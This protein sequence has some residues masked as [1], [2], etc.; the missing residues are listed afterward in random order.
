MNSSITPG[1]GRV[2]A[3]PNPDILKT[4]GQWNLGLTI[5][6]YVRI[7]MTNSVDYESKQQENSTQTVKSLKHLE[8]T[9]YIHIHIIYVVY[10][11]AKFALNMRNYA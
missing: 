10:E 2:G 11:K 4:S 3:N 1:G 6:G 8:N 9:E 5:V 7:Y